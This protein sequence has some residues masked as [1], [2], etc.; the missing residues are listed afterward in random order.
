MDGLIKNKLKTLQSRRLL[1]GL[2]KE[3][4]IEFI[5]DISTG[6]RTVKDGINFNLS[7]SSFAEFFQTFVHRAKA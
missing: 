7:F 6:Q 5:S 3:S 1:Q 2:I 4:E